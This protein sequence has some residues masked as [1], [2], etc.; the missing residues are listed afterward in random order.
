MEK[1][2]SMKVGAMILTIVLLPGCNLLKGKDVVVNRDNIVE[3][4]EE[5]NSK[6]SETIDLED[7]VE[8]V[9]FDDYRNVEDSIYTYDD[10]NHI[11][12]L[13]IRIDDDFDYSFLNELHNL[14]FLH[15]DDYSS[16][17]SLKNVDGSK[18][19]KLTSVAIT[20]DPEV[21]EFNSKR[22]GFLK[23]IKRIDNLILGDDKTPLII[24]EDYLE[25]LTNVH[26]LYLSVNKDNSN[27]DFDDLDYLDFLYLEGDTDSVSR[28]DLRELKEEGVK[29]HIK[30]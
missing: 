16:G 14:E 22:Y 23:D 30:K 7:K 19:G 12:S 24:D 4:N 11:N 1:K 8:L 17:Q 15:L 6:L 25:E 28:R 27:I 2:K 21:G 3:I 13:V 10:L 5:D 20:M 26:C 18:I 9:T 29:V